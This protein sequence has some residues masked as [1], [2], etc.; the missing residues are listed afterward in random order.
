MIQNHFPI[1][2][3]AKAAGGPA[4]SGNYWATR[5]YTDTQYAMFGVDI[6]V[7]SSGI[8]YAVGRATL[9]S[10]QRGFLARLDAD[11]AA[12]HLLEQQ[13]YTNNEY[14]HSIVV[15]N[16]GAPHWLAHPAGST[17][18]R[19]TRINTI[20]MSVSWGN[21]V[22]RASSEVIPIGLAA[23]ASNNT[24]CLLRTVDG[25]DAYPAIHKQNASG[26]EQWTASWVPSS[27]GMTP[28]GV[29]TDASSNVYVLAADA[30]PNADALIA[31][32][33]SSG[34]LQWQREFAHATDEPTFVAGAVDA[35]GNVYVAV[36]VETGS[37]TIGVV[38]YNSSGTLQAA[39]KISP[40]MSAQV[41]AAAVGAEIAADGSLCIAYQMETTAGA[42]GFCRVSTETL[43][44]L[45]GFV[46]EVPSGD[47]EIRSFALHGAG[48]VF[49]CGTRL[50]TDTYLYVLRLPQFAPSTY[51]DHVKV[52]PDAHSS[53]A[54]SSYTA[55]TPTHSISSGPTLSLENNNG[56][57]SSLNAYENTLGVTFP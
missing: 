54:W 55:S 3:G 41:Y 44:P 7:D 25:F 32:L 26:V 17:W 13:G 42:C 24:I 53:A 35:S 47:M 33:N 45:S 9:S 18:S 8:S 52:T 4:G 36:T 21:D 56:S 34:A 31:K 11:G 49:L 15:D 27:G 14:R 57:L 29:F 40:L 5:V 48:D 12:T 6:E 50:G 37:C 46:V 51:N 30:T 16:G 19:L 20:G 28:R 1:L 39:R 23:D 38:K 43:E 2:F 10:V 22:D